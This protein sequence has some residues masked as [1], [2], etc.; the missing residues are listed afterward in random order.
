MKDE[1]NSAGQDDLRSSSMARLLAAGFLKAGRPDR[2][3]RAACRFEGGEM[4]SRTARRI[5]S[6]LGVEV[7]AWSYGTC[8]KVSFF[9]PRTVVGR[10][11]SIGPEVR[12]HGRNHPIDSRVMHAL[13]YNSSLGFVDEDALDFS[14]CEIGHDAWIGHGAILTPA[15]RRVGIGSIVA[16]GA[17][18]TKDVPDF[19][20]VAGNPARLMRYRFDEP[21]RRE[22][23]DSEWWNWS[24]PQIR[25]RMDWIQERVGR[26]AE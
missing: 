12:R 6:S 17:V 8:F 4:Q 21:Q 23:I 13:A 24:A 20:I 22:I 2:A 10:F 9:A 11:V 19:A 14:R 7:G 25:E 15:V 5:L 1:P 18:V 3:I 16:A 26:V